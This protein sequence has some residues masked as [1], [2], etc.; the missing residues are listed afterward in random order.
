M[1]ITNLPL[2]YVFAVGATLLLLGIFSSK[3]SSWVNAP[4]LL[5]FLAVGMLAGSEGISQLSFIEWDGIHFSDYGVANLIGT[6]AL[7]YILFSGGLGTHWKTIKKVAV[8]GGILASAGVLITAVVMGL[9]AHLIFKMPLEHAILLGAVVSSTDAA[10]VFAI[11]RSRS[12]GLKGELQPLLELESGSNDPMAAFLTLFMIGI[13]GHSGDSYWSI[14]PS[15]ATKMGVGLLYGLV[16]GR[17]AAHLINKI[18]LEYDGLYFV[19]GIGIVIFTFG[20]CEILHGNGFMAVYVCGLVMGNRP[21]LFKNGFIKFHDGIS[22]LMQ[23]VM[24]L[25]LGLL[26]FP[27][28][29]PAIAV[30]GLVL[31]VV[32]MFVARPVSVFLCMIKSKFTFKE[33]LLISWVGLRGA[34]PIVLATFPAIY[35]VEGSDTIFSLVFFIV[36]TS[37]LIQ[38]KTLMPVARLLHLDKPLTETLRAPLE[39]EETGHMKS[40]MYEQN[41]P[42]GSHAIGQDLVHLPLPDSTRILLIRRKSG[43]VVPIGSTVIQEGDGLLFLSDPQ[44]ASTAIKILTSPESVESD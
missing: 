20:T 2:D 34:A 19:L 25:I 1:D 4:A 16:I 41:I 28:R 23:V 40:Q 9:F 5:M 27:S 42:S 37:V 44:D 35:G 14:L 43:F 33:Q 7:C 17:L 3:V 26:V 22:W 15:F 13:I 8:T 21:F 32:L 10:A 18:S 38:G 12:V 11:L 29:L 6:L 31:S 36:L 24:F 30:E 39:F